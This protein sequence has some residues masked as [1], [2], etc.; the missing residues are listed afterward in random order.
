ME[1]RNSSLRGRSTK[2]A[3][4][5]LMIV[6][7]SVVFDLAMASEGFVFV[8]DRGAYDVSVYQLSGDEITYSQTIAGNNEKNIDIAIDESSQIAFVSNESGNYIKLLDTYDKVFLKNIVIDD[9]SSISG[10]VYDAKRSKLLAVGRNT[11]I[12]YELN[13]DNAGL[14]LDLNRIITLSDID[15]AN[16]IDINQDTLYVTE[17][18]YNGDISSEQVFTFDI[19]NNYSFIETIDMVEEVVGITYDPNENVLYGGIYY[20]HNNI[21]KYLFSTSTAIVKNADDSIVGLTID[22]SEPSRIITTS[23]NGNSVAL[24]DTSDW[25][26]ESEVNVDPL[27]STDEGLIGPAGLA[28]IHNDLIPRRIGLT[29]TDN[30]DPSCVSPEDSIT[31][32]VIVDPNGFDHEDL[33]VSVIIPEAMDYDDPL[34][35]NYDIATR[36]YTWEIGTLNGTNSVS[37]EFSGTINY[38]CEPGIP[39]YLHVNAVSDVATASKREYTDVCCVWGGDI[40]Y[41]DRNASG[42]NTGTSWQNAYT[43]L[44][45]A[46]ERVRSNDSNDPNNSNDCSETA[47]WVAGGVYSPGVHSTSTFD[48]P[49]DVEVYGGMKGDEPS[50]YD[51]SAR[52]AILYKS[53][54]TGNNKNNIVVDMGNNTKLH[55]FTIEDGDNWGVIGNGTN[56]TLEYCVITSNNEQGIYCNNGNLT[57]NWCIV[58]GNGFRGIYHDGSGKT[59]TVNNCKVYDNVQD[60]IYVNSSTP[61]ILNSEIHHNGSTPYVSYYGIRLYYASG[62][63]IRNCTIVYNDSYGIHHSWGTEPDISNCIFW[64]NNDNGTQFYNCSPTNSYT[65]DPVFAYLNPDLGNFHLSTTS[66]VIDSYEDTSIPAGETDIDG[67]ERVYNTEVDLGADEVSEDCTDDAYIANNLFDI[68]ADGLVNNYEFAMFSKAWLAHDPNEPDYA[69]SDPN[70][71]AIWSRARDYNFD[72]DGDSQY[73]I[74]SADLLKLANDWA[75]QA[76]WKDFDRGFAM[77]GMGGDGEMTAMPMGMDMMVIEAPAVEPTIEEQ[78]AGAESN[79]DFLN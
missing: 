71:Y 11:N 34:N 5:I 9:A 29:I 65:S 36:T 41:V 57:V 50:D 30:I 25:T 26:S 44:Q 68:N 6:L 31:Y 42:F 23:F 18:F 37:K 69:P 40:V 7:V 54:L 3:A 52:E 22:K 46:L 79:L 49:D 61:T 45:E 72:K 27:S 15:Y 1:S 76:C 12:I 8:A 63:E 24:W 28:H 64:G 60:G 43:E 14:D 16:G 58:S 38:N 39:I 73:V 75:W 13:W 62:G 55:G 2:T 67:E 70:E 10:L 4:F 66:P 21:V 20:G 78:L 59:L 17:Y 77:M 53:I 33:T 51:P 19:S 35:P 47:I 56:Y 74:D 32:T 48:I